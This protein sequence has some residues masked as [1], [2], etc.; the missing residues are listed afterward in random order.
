MMVLLPEPSVQECIE[1]SW[2]I[3]NSK[4]ILQCFF[5]FENK[6]G[7]KYF[8]NTFKTTDICL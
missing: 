5:N 1:L 3:K 2:R 6:K 7:G 4:K 8:S